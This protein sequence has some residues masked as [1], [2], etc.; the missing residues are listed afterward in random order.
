MW[1]PVCISTTSNI[2]RPLKLS[3]YSNFFGS[4]LTG[5]GYYERL[6]ISEEWDSLL[7]H[8][9]NA[10]KMKVTEMPTQCKK[11]FTGFVEYYRL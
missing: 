10:N 11:R 9:Y 6:F 1:V 7:K 8:K 5:S 2:A 3:I 4:N